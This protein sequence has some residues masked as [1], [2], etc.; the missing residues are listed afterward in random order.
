MKNAKFEIYEGFTKRKK[1]YVVTDIDAD[2]VV[3]INY[4]KKLFKCSEAH[5]DFTSGYIY[6]GELYIDDPCKPG[7]KIVGV[8]YYVR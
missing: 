1:K 6:K 2:Y 5:I 8:A 3:V 4:A 7:A